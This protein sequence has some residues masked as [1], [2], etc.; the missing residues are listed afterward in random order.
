MDIARTQE[1]EH[2]PADS[3]LA[4]PLLEGEQCNVRIIRLAAGQA[5]PPH[6][7]GVSDLMLFVADGEGQ[8]DTPT[9]TQSFSRGDLAFY[10]GDEELRVRNAGNAELTLLAFL[11]PKFATR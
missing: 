9:G 8:L 3:F 11:A 4:R 1:V 7:H 2:A 5:L 6:R 10:R